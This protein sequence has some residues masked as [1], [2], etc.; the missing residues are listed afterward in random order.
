MCF[1]V[2]LPLF[3]SDRNRA[4]NLF[5]QLVGLQ[6]YGCLPNLVFNQLLGNM[7]MGI[8]WR[9]SQTHGLCQLR[10]CLIASSSHGAKCPQ[11]FHLEACLQDQCRSSSDN[12]R[13]IRLPLLLALQSS[14]RDSA[15]RIFCA[16]CTSRRFIDSPISP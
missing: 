2:G 11:A 6:E 14:A 8:G 5:F 4:S 10:S 15:W 16:L 1:R 13:V 9:S 7:F 3:C 12:Q